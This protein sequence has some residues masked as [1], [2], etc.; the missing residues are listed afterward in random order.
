MVELRSTRTGKRD[1]YG[2]EIL[3]LTRYVDGK[4]KGFCQVV[5]G[6][7]GHQVFRRAA[8]P[9]AREGSLEPIPEG[10]YRVGAV[11]WA[12]RPGDWTKTFGPGF[13]PFI[14]T[15]EPLQ[16]LAGGRGAF[17]FHLDANRLTGSPGTAGCEG[18]ISS[19]DAQTFLDWKVPA[20]T[21]F[22]ADHGLGSAPPLE[23]SKDAEEAEEPEDQDEGTWLKHYRKPERS[24]S[25]YGGDPLAKGHLVV[26]WDTERGTERWTLNGQRLPLGHMKL[27]LL[28]PGEEI[29]LSAP[30]APPAPPATAENQLEATLVAAL[31]PSPTDGEEN[32]PEDGP[33]PEA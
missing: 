3:R 16:Q 7:P 12:G 21:T 19:T 2:C 5:T 10:R 18:F 25:F 13:G 30:P 27:E 29:D 24:A 8:D 31:A 20:G 22:V 17:L 28:H 15:L 9:G 14:V 11:Q 23:E 6:A 1:N 26:E 4:E 32:P 33:P